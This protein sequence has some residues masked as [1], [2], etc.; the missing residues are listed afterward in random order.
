MTRWKLSILVAFALAAGN[1]SCGLLSPLPDTG[2]YAV[3]ASVDDLRGP[4]PEPDAPVGAL[5]VG[6]G[7]VAVPDYLLR[8]AIVTREGG[9]R[10]VPS[11]TERWAEP[12]ERSLERALAIN[13]RREP[14]VA[15]VIVHPWY[16]TERPEV[17]VEIEF[18][19]CEQ[20]ETARVVVAARWRIRW[21]DGSRAPVERETRLER[22]SAGA[23]GAQIARSLSEALAELCKQIGDELNP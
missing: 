2:R 21:L 8:A 6:L 4:A 3:L 15:G 13:L 16:E 19:R 12:F 10:L 5:Q 7:P 11:P 14:G 20:E 22:P 18:S 9:T 23:K 17:Q 1:A